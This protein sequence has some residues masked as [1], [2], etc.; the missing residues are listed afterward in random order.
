MN[1]AKSFFNREKI[2]N[3]KKSQ[4]IICVILFLI[5]FIPNIFTLFYATDLQNNLVMQVSYF[6]LSLFVWIFPL[7]FLSVKNFFR[8]GILFFLIS[9][10]EIGFVKTTGLPINTGIIDTVLSTNFQEAKEQL[11]SN[12]PAIIFLFLTLVLYCFLLRFV[13]KEKWSKKIKWVFLSAFILLNG[14][15]FYKMFS[16]SEEQHSTIEKMEISADNTYRKYKKVFPADI[17]LN[18]YEVLKARNLNK[19]LEKEV[20]NFSFGAKQ[21]SPNQ[22]TET[23]ILIIGETARRHNFHLYGYER[24]TTPELEKIKNLI[25]FSDVNSCATLTLLSVPQIIT[26]A[27]PENFEV[28]FKEKSV[29][30]LFHEAGFYTAWIGMQNI[31]S[32]IVKRL[33]SVTDYSYFSKSDVSSAQFFDTDIIK[34]L[35]TVLEDKSHKK[36][37]IVLHTFGSHFRYSNRYPSDFEKF[38]PN[39]SRSGYSNI[40]VDYKKELVNSYDNSILFT[41][42]FLASAIHEVEKTNAVSGLIYLSDHGENL[43][44]DGKTI[45]HGGEKPTSFEYQIP[46]ITWFSDKFKNKY[47]EK[48]EA[49]EKNKNKKASSTST[50]YTFADMANIVYK[51]SESEKNKSLA[52]PHYQEP[53]QRKLYTS[54]GEVISVN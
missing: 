1:P 9:P 41:D 49:L 2:Q 33:K 21:I 50:F 43:Y 17:V 23:Y 11:L 47:P 32:P 12:L 29:V 54:K 25:P 45:F 8:L 53:K 30:D 39:I 35:K 22:E 15:L 46:Y 27:N 31:S 52:N 34:N 13:G 10:I 51:N 26:R 3:D 14:V 5:L 40:S 4:R 37:F 7:L 44:D 28:Q 16:L 6:A 20:E 19:N 24:E 18:T 36:K 42:H 38:T 48:I